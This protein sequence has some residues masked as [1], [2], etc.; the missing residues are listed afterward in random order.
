MTAEDL[1]EA[2]AERV[3]GKWPERIIYRDVCPE[4][5][6]RP[7]FFLQTLECEPEDA[8]ASLVSWDAKLLLILYDEKDDHYET[9]SERL[10]AI[11][12]EIFR[13]FAAPLRVGDRVVLVHAKGVGREP[14]EAYVELSSS[15]MDGRD[16]GAPEAPIPPVAE[17]YAIKYTKRS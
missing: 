7:S 12:T 5:F 15:W 16:T 6:D 14:G 3:A 1:A 11:Q 8:N 13:L 10:Q 9:S 17:E 4:N 2:I